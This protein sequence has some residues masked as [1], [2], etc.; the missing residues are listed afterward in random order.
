MRFKF[1]LP[2]FENRHFLV[3]CLYSC[4]FSHC[5]PF[6]SIRMKEADCALFLAVSSWSLSSRYGR[7]GGKAVQF[8]RVTANYLISTRT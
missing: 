4:F 8:P 2:R 3:H 5:S 1:S 6:P 7:V